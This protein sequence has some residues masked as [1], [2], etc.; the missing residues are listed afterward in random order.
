[1]IIL[2]SYSDVIFEL[3]RCSDELLSGRVSRIEL[4]LAALK[5]ILLHVLILV[6][7]DAGAADE[8][9]E[10]AASTEA[11]EHDVAPDLSL[12]AN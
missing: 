6:A 7:L 1:M 3:A 2:F 11:S 5:V 4:S 12:I 8:D 10:N 9:K